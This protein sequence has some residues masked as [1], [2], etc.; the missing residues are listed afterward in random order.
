MNRLSHAVAIIGWG[1]QKGVVIDN[2]GTKKDIPYWYCRNSWTTKWAD[3]GYFKMPHYPYN[4]MSQ[5][6][7]QIIITT[8]SGNFQGGGMVMITTSMKPELKKIGEIRK[9]AGSLIDKNDPKYSVEA[10][11]KG[12]SGE[13]KKSL[14]K[15]ILIILGIIALVILTFFIYKKITSKNPGK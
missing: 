3:G 13:S 8:P 1:T 14:V 10:K 9:L 15:Y 2:D 6:D 11:D 4:K 5:F 7:K 12:D